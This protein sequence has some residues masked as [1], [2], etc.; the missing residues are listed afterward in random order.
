M[1]ERNGSALLGTDQGLSPSKQQGGNLW[2]PGL[3]VWGL[4]RMRAWLVAVSNGAAGSGERAGERKKK[5]VI[6]KFFC[7]LEG[8]RDKVDIG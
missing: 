7:A 5:W 3:V 4:G 2:D 8:I 6:D 1:I